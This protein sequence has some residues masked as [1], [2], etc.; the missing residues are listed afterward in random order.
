MNGVINK[1]TTAQ[2]IAEH[3]LSVSPDATEYRFDLFLDGTCTNSRTKLTDTEFG[4]ILPAL[5]YALSKNSRSKKYAIVR[6]EGTRL[7]GSHYV[8]YTIVFQ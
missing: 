7:N 8:Q 2:H 5:K 4:G 3:L 6:N 1:F